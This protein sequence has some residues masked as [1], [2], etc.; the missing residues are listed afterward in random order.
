MSLL[1]MSEISEMKYRTSNT[2]TSEEYKFTRK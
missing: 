1:Y 2:V